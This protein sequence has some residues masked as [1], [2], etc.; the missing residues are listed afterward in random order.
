[1][2]VQVVEPRA[3]ILV[4]RRDLSDIHL[5]LHWQILLIT[6]LVMVRRI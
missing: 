3:D 6:V 5:N 2:N 4:N 1:M